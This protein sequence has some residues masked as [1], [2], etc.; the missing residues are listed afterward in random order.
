MQTDKFETQLEAVANKYDLRICKILN[1]LRLA[2]V[3][4]GY[5]VCE[6][7]NDGDISGPRWS[8]YLEAP[9]DDDAG[10]DI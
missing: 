4:E 6:P 9:T 8:I 1:K 2:L 5:D 3:E 10:L 7:Y